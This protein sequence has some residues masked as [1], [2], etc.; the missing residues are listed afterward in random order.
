VY[1]LNHTTLANLYNPNMHYLG[2]ITA[3]S[4][5]L[6]CSDNPDKTAA[7]TESI[8]TTH[9]DDTGSEPDTQPPEDTATPPDSGTPPPTDTARPDTGR[10]GDSGADTGDTG[11][12]ITDTGTPP[13]EPAFP[14]LPPTPLHTEGRWILDATA[15]RFKLASV[16]WYGFE[17]LDYVPAGLEIA[18]RSDIAFQITEMGFNSVRLPFSI[19]MIES[20]EPVA[21]HVVAAN[22]ELEGLTPIQVMDAVIDALATHGLVVILDNHSSEA[23]WYSPDHGLWYT[24]AYPESAWLAMWR[25]LSHR[26][27]DHP[28]VVG[29]DLRNELRAGATWG[30]DP[31]T[32][33]KSAAERAAA[34][35]HAIDDTKLIMLAGIGYGADFTGVYTD[36]ITLTVPGRLVYSPHD[37]SWFH[38]YID[39]YSD[40]AIELGS[41][42]GFLLVEG[43]PYT[44]PIWLGEF[45]TCNTGPDCIAGDTADGAWF[46]T[47]IEYLNAGDIDW[48]YWPLNGTMARADDREYGAVDWFG[49]IDETWSEPSLPEL[50]EELQTIQP[51]WAFPE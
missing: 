16:N 34:E 35:I 3:L 2:S 10:P 47:F 4:L 32:D 8:T 33:W 45:G 49:V 9:R 13:P 48:A 39:S 22:P 37:Y 41:W 12:G 29:F 18:H 36:P 21:D 46:S 30:G 27:L 26:Y 43:E 19:E 1:K 40:L 5:L 7:D 6:A 25:E 42:W 14:E 15:A 24:D 20:T 38:G 51:A 11:A 28:A 50:L 17:E 44:A 23:V 31:A